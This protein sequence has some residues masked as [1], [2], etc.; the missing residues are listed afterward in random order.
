[1]VLYGYLMVNHYTSRS[2]SEHFF[3]ILIY[4]K[5][6]IMSTW[7]LFSSEIILQKNSSSYNL[8]PLRFAET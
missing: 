2:S 5:F 1:M 3:H 4:L 8:W 7:I 6:D